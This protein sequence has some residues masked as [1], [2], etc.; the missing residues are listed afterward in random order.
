MILKPDL[1]MGVDIPM[2]IWIKKEDIHPLD[3]FLGWVSSIKNRH[4]KGG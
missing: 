1:A 2:N 3:I 4:G